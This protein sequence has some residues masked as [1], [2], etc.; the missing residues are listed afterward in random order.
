[1]DDF[2]LIGHP[3]G[4]SMSK[5][6]HEAAFKCLGLPYSYGLFDVTEEKLHSFLDGAHHR[7]LNVTIPLKVEALKRMDALSPEAEVVGAVNTIEFRGGKKI[8]HNTDATGFIRSLEDANVAVRGKNVLVLGAG[9]AARG[10]VFNL[11]SEGARVSILN[12]DSG[13]ARSLADE[14]LKKVGGK[15]FVAAGV[16]D[17]RDSDIVV[18]ATSVGMSPKTEE[19]LVPDEFLRPDLTVVEIVYNP[20][21]TRLLRGAKARGC[22][23]VDGVGMLVHQG[24]E[25][26]RIWLD[27]EPP[28][29]VMRSAVLENLKNRV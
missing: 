3:V 25:S 8:G 6:M 10:I 27:I 23:T 20:L 2:G 28:I 7:G 14:T 21:E 1:M 17:V 22:R 12:R 9:G 18:N 4:H 5:V 24:A 26:L 15:I 29:N 19:T 11:A 13:K 16:G